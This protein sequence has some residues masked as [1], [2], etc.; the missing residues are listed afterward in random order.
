MSETF[1]LTGKVI[2]KGEVKEFSSGFTKQEFVVEVEDGKYPQPTKLECVKDKTALLDDVHVGNTVTA[3]FNIRGNEHND[4]YY[5]NLQCWKLD[6]E[7][8]R[9]Q[10]KDEPAQKHETTGKLVDTGDQG[11]GDEIPF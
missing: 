1:K 10:R 4:N 8:Q 11:E 5:V 7:G 2:L 9:E 3:F 6:K